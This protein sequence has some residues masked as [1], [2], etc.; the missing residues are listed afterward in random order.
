MPRSGDRRQ[1]EAPARRSAGFAAATP[2]LFNSGY[3]VLSALDGAPQQAT[4]K[5][6]RKRSICGTAARRRRC[7]S[8]PTTASTPPARSSLNQRLDEI[9]TEMGRGTGDHGRGRRRRGA[10][11]RLQPGEQRAHPLRCRGDHPRHL[12]RLGL[13]PAGAAPGRDRGR[14]Q[15]GDGRGRLRHPHPPLP[16]PRRAG[17]W[18][19]TNT[20]TRSGRR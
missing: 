14:A 16:R 12:P 3:F 18:A 11:Q 20:S 9:A 6:R 7:S 5:R 8:S 19:A 4:P 15:P 10:A 13:R 17:R 1:S 2:G